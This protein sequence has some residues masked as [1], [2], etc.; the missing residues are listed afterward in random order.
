MLLAPAWWIT[1]SDYAAFSNV[2]QGVQ[3]QCTELNTGGY[4]YDVAHLPQPSN[5]NISFDWRNIGGHNEASRFYD[6]K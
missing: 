2:V 1:E 6:L 4:L 3:I 5:R